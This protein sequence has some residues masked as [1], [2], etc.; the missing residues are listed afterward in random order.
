[1]RKLGIVALGAAAA[2]TL[3]GCAS[4]GSGASEE[5]AEIRVWLVGTD[6]PDEA[7]EYLVDTFEK[8]N[9]G[10]T[11]V[12]EEQSWDGLVDTPDHEPLRLRQPRRR[13]GRQHP[14]VGLHLG[15]R[16]PRPDR[17]LRDARRRR[18]AP[19]LRR[20]RHVRRQVLR[21]AATT[22][23]RAS[24]STEGRPRGG[25]TDGADDAR[26]VHLERRRRSRQPNPG[27]RASGGPARTGTTRF[28]TSGRTAAR[29]P[30]PTARSGTRSSRAPSRSPVS[31]Q[32]QEV[33][34]TA[35]T[36]PKDGNET[37]PEVGFCDGT[38]RCSSRPRAGSSGRSSLRPT[39]R[40]P[41]APTRRRT[42]A[43]SPFRAWTAAPPRSSPAARTSRISAK[44]AHPEL[45]PERA[46]DHPLATSYQTIYGENG[47]V[48]AKLSLADTL[49]TD[50]VAKAIAAAAGN[51]KLT[52]AS[53]NWADVEAA[54]ILTGPV[55]Q[56][57]AGRRRQGARRG[58]RRGDRGDPQQLV[59]SVRLR[60]AAAPPPP[61]R[62]PGPTATTTHV[63]RPDRSG[64]AAR[65]EP[66]TSRSTTMT[67]VD[68]GLDPAPQRARGRT[69]H[70]TP[71]EAGR[72][73]HPADPRRLHP[74][75]AA[76]PRD[77]RAG[78]HHRASRSSSSSSRRSRS[79]AAPRSSAPPPEFVGFDNYASVLTD[80][81]FWAVLVRTL[82]FSVV[83]RRRHDVRSA[84]SSR[85]DDAAPEGLPHP[86]SRSACC[87]PGPCRRS[88][89]PSSGAGC[90][91][92][93][94]GVV[95]YVLVNWFGM[96]EYFRHSWLIDPLSF[97]L[98]AGIIIVWQRSA[99]RR[100]HALRGPH[101]G[102]RRGARGRAARRRGRVSAI[103]AHHLPVPASR[104]S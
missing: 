101:P 25:R 19:G 71:A 8:E 4:G 14:G 97:F 6:T 87:S 2:L 55:R 56:D 99:V 100:L 34:T 93:H 51:A 66:S 88:R 27:S 47:L 75:L 7:R 73:P 37:R 54:G 64:S 30:S 74:L 24:S 86:R 92:P 45:A 61:H 12:I 22:R 11:L 98:V 20:G 32:V 33:M 9:P 82:V 63:A 53:P 50:E 44:S 72:P 102:A 76:H 35:S 96:E 104:S 29:S 16:V 91:T 49:G 17:R 18:P 48:P 78:R 60:G 84:R 36:A 69:P 67:T 3:A 80:P 31:T 26:R 41:A 1:M 5:G 83:M 65:P 79:S 85:S 103:P 59:G 57:R 94:Y 95:N 38:S 70:G 68:N 90:S 52:P 15:R 40:R 81:V 10:S 39:P 62:T 23:A 58:R 46:G 43:S 42:S 77:H 21:R 13:R 28:P 89:R